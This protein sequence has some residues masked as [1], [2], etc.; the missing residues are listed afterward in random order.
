MCN[1]EFVTVNDV[2]V[3]QRCG[4]TV[5]YDNKVLFDRKIANYKPKKKK[6]GKNGKKA[7]RTLRR[8][9]SFY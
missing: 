5:T 7:K 9:H 6:R 8:L 3:C 2:R 4:M 1:H